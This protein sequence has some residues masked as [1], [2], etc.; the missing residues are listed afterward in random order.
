VGRGDE[1]EVRRRC[2]TVLAGD[3]AMLRGERIVIESREGRDEHDRRALYAALRGNPVTYEHLVASEDPGLRFA[4]ALAWAYGAGGRW[5]DRVMP[6][7]D[8]VR[9]V[10]TARQRRETRLP[11]V[12][13]GA[14]FTFPS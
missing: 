11:T 9:D 8:A 10:G 7:I 4:D 5:R 14:A 2:L 1:I 3:L 13:K 6:V 12:R